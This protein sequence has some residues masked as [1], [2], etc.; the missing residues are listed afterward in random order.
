VNLTDYRTGEGAV[1]DVLGLDFARAS[2][3]ARAAGDY[4][5]MRDL[6]SG[7]AAGRFDEVRAEIGEAIDS[8]YQEVALALQGG[9]GYVIHGNVDRPASLRA[10]LPAGF[11]YVHGQVV[12]IEGIRFGFAG[13]GAPT[14]LQAEGE[15]SDDEMR[16]LLEHIGPVDVLCTHVPAAVHPLRTDVITGRAERG[17]APILEYLIREKPRVHLFG[18]VHQPQ[19]TTWRLGATRCRNVGYFRATGRPVR[20]DRSWIE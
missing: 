4:Q 11:E 8:Q 15:V 5:G 6:W 12:E 19:A 13:G 7:Q 2:A 10:S 9:S 18:D 3:T 20:I 1:A 16:L 14:P 17:S